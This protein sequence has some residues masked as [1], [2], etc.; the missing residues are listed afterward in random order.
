M[1]YQRST[2]KLKWPEGHE[3]HGLEVRMRRLNV[4]R[5]ADV[6]DMADSL[7]GGGQGVAEQLRAI[8]DVITQGL[9]GWNL[10]LEDSTPVPADEDG[11][12]DQDFGMLVAILTAWLR[13]ATSIPLD[14]SAPSSPGD[15][16]ASSFELPES[17]MEE[18]SWAPLLSSSQENIGAPA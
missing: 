4:G 11:V 9:L 18:E 16:N 14:L 15:S 3:L 17:S 6:Q 10:E 12:A 7:G 1:G 5:L 2:L 8:T 13:V